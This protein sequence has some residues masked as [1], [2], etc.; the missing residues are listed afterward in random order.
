MGNW[1]GWDQNDKNEKFE[2]SLFKKY[3]VLKLWSKN[4][5]DLLKIFT[6]DFF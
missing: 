2:I 5:L 6:N 3:R 4:L 1:G